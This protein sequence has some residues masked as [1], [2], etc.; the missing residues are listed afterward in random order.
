MRALR[1]LA[2]VIAGLMLLLTYFLVQ[3]A[4][5]DAALHERTLDAMQQLILNDAALQRDVLR[6]RTGLLRNYDPLVRS[7][8]NMRDAAARLQTADH[9]ASGP[10]Q[11]EIQRRIQAV[12]AAVRDQDSL[13]DTFKSSNALLQNS[14]NYLGHLLAR[15]G[16]GSTRD[17]V[18]TEIGALANVL[19][20]F[21]Q[22][23]RS[24]AAAGLA[25]TL[26]R[27]ERLQV[28]GDRQQT[29]PTLLSHGRLVAAALPQMEG[30]LAR[31]QAA[32]IRD[33]TLDL[34]NMYLDFY[35]RADARA[36]IFRILLYAV[37]VALAGYVGYLFFRLRANALSLQ[38]RLSTAAP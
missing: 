13:V 19:L 16:V 3:G 29:V 22:D 7:V 34:Q 4:T 30:L 21:V 33:R 20:G 18:D 17:P 1:S 12:D 23:P 2:P 25:A 6:A 28:S 14:L 35:S 37:A 11:R 9:L 36:G 5:P 27:L 32:P 26:D 15:I 24:D 8:E 10:M 31:L 38:N